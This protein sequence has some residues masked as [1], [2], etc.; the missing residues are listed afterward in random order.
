MRRDVRY[1]CPDEINGLKDGY[2]AACRLV[3]TI[4]QP[5]ELSVGPV[6][7]SVSMGLASTSDGAVPPEMLV[8]QADVAM[9]A[10]KSRGGNRVE[11]F[12][13]RAYAARME[14]QRTENELRA[15]LDNGELALAYQP[16]ID[17]RYGRV[18]GVEALLRWRHPTKGLLA[19]A[20]FIDVAERSGLIIPIGR[21][22]IGEACAQLARWDVE[23]GAASPHSVYINVSPRQL[24]A[25]DVIGDLM[26]AT[27]TTGISA[28]R[29]CLEITETEALQDPEVAAVVF[30]AATE[31]GVDL[32]ID[33]FGTGYASLSR[34]T[35][36]PARIIKLDATFVREV[37]QRRQAVAVISAILIMA[38]NLRQD[39]IAEGLE[40]EADVDTLREMGCEYG[41]GYHL[42]RPMEPSALG[43]WIAARGH[44]QP[45]RLA[46]G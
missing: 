18:R 21:W 28:R 44:L 31:L 19:A 43:P 4:S 35:E 7:V 5:F 16:I 25:S 14:Q 30:Q 23:L 1:L 12:D 24:K 33:D 41:Q 38:H 36:I 39:V 13:E 45:P 26:Q 27:S 17:L 10:A 3:E 6:R 20:D 9:Y 37:R 8:S 46:A 34:L 22:V 29:V 11:M 32:A 15:A 2:A 42:S 40:N